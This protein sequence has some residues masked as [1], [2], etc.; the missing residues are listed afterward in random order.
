MSKVSRSL[1]IRLFY[2]TIWS[3]GLKTEFVSQN[4]IQ[5]RTPIER[6]NYL[7]MKV[8]IELLSFFFINTK[9][10]SAFLNIVSLS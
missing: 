6:R 10:Q 1:V 8:F 3:V 5:S 2:P 9:I 7:L 4:T